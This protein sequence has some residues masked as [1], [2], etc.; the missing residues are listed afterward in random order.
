MELYNKLSKK[1]RIEL[2]EKAGENR[3]TL[4][5]YK[6]HSIKN[7]EIFRNFLFVELTKIDT[8]IDK[9]G[10]IRSEIASYENNVNHKL[11]LLTDIKINKKTRLSKIQDADFALETSKLTKSQIISNAA[12]SLLAQANLSGNVLLRLIN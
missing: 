10:L 2:I 3:F 8:A 5:F 9:I 4:S 6:Y 7:P 1:Q 12:T 11:D